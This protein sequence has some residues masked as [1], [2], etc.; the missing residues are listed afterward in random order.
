[1]K[2]IEAAIADGAQTVEDIGALTTAG[3]AC[4]SCKGELKQCLLA[5]GKKVPA[6][7]A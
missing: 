4:G 5:H 2:K 7:A 1:M 3:T 6:H